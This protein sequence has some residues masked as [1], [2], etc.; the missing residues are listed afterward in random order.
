MNHTRGVTLFEV[1]LSLSIVTVLLGIT[2]FALKTPSTHL[3]SNDLKAMLQQARFE[4]IKRSAA[5]SVNWEEDKKAFVMRAN[6]HNAVNC[7]GT[8]IK[9]KALNEYADLSY[10]ASSFHGI[11]WL[12]TGLPRSC[13]GLLTPATLHFSNGRTNHSLTINSVGKVSLK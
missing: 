4:A 3:Y 2:D 12:P 8:I 7:N 1:L 10:S 5:V 6:A 13:N 11:V 9:N